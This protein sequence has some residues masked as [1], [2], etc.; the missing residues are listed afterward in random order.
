[1]R[2][3]RTDW[4]RCVC[5][6][7]YCDSEADAKRKAEA[8]AFLTGR[9]HPVDVYRCRHAAGVWHWTDTGIPRSECEC[10]R[11]QMSQSTAN[12][13]C[14]RINRAVGGGDV[15]ARPYQCAHG[16]HHWLWYP[17]GKKVRYCSG[18]ELP[19]Y[20]DPMSAQAVATFREESQ[21]KTMR[22]YR[23]EF[24]RWHLK[25][26]VDSC[27]TTGTHQGEPLW[28]TYEGDTQRWWP[29]CGEVDVMV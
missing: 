16:G 18:C 9:D 8:V 6:K 2:P 11:R 20:P 5:G 19:A 3:R 21:H 29:C 7:V 1:M 24:S 28:V 15:E 25:E 4:P 13:E 14:D 27:T 22:V 17:K 26:G 12:K 23:C 10:G